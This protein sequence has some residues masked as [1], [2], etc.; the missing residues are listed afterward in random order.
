MVDAHRKVHCVNAWERVGYII[1]DACSHWMVVVNWLMNLNCLVCRGEDLSDCWWKANKW[2][3]VSSNNDFSSFDPISNF[4]WLHTCYNS[5]V[6]EKV[7]WNRIPI[8]AKHYYFSSRILPP[9]RYWIRHMWCEAALWLWCS[10]FRFFRPRH[11][12][13]IIFLCIFQEV[14]EWHLFIDSILQVTSLEIYC[15]QKSS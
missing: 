2:F 14:I 11:W 6:P 1:I 13:F 7:F 10:L 4:F 15:T 3:V 9:K 12:S 5:F 8:I